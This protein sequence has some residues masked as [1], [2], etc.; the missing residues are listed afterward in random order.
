MPK[1][2]SGNLGGNS[3][4]GVAERGAGPVAE[5]LAATPPVAQDPATATGL[6]R[7]RGPS[8]K[9]RALRLLA[10]REHSRA[11]LAT[12][13][14]RQLQAA[15]AREAQ[16]LARQAGTAP[17]AAPGAAPDTAAQATAAGGLQLRQLAAQVETVLDELQRH[18]LL[19][20][21]RAAASL[22]A[23]RAPRHGERRLKHDLHAKGL[24]P[25]L[26]AQTLAQARDSEAPRALALW[27][28]RFGQVAVDAAAHAKQVRFLAGRGFTMDTISRVLRQARAEAADAREE[29]WARADPPFDLSDP[30]AD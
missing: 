23:V 13:L 6:S 20:D 8:L 2:V 7:W 9:G 1:S 12:K 17:Q 26:I 21:E 11:E 30:V 25:A 14:K 3:P 15:S 18:G 5:A 28:R 27:Q 16:R 4:K 24:D 10:Q 19:S 29:A 22:L